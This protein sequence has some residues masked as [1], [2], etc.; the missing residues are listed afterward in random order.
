MLPITRRG[1]GRVFA[2]AGQ[3]TRRGRGGPPSG[4]AEAPTLARSS[5]RAPM[6]GSRPGAWAA[7]WA[8]VWLVGLLVAVVLL[9]ARP[10]QA[11]AATPAPRCAAGGH[12]VACPYGPAQLRAAY[13]IQPLI[14]QGIDGRGRTVVLLEQAQP[15][16]AA[17]TS[18]I[19]RDLDAFDQRFN[20]PPVAL[21]V[22]PTPADADPNAADIEEVMDAEL[23]HGVAPGAHIQ[24]LLADLKHPVTA[25]S[26]AVSKRLGDVIS[27]SLEF[28]ERCDTVAQAA[29]LHRVIERAA[30]QGM[31]LVASSGDYGAAG[32]PCVRGGILPANATATVSLLVADPL[33]T[34]V[35]GTRLDVEQSTGH[36]LG[37][38]VWNS[39]PRNQPVPPSAAPTGPGTNGSGTNGGRAYASVPHTEASGG[40]FSRLFPRPPFQAGVPGIGAGRGVPD[41]AA[42]A[43]PASPIATISAS[44]DGAAVL[45]GG[46]GTSIGAPIWAGLAAL[47][48]QQAGR[49][50][51]PLNPSLYR[52]GLGPEHATAFHDIT[53][54]NNDAQFPPRVITGFSAGPGWDPV[55]GWGSPDAAVLIPLLVHDATAHT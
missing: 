21:T 41:V 11:A 7:R 51:G 52:I 23:V 42:V 16:G 3:E 36:Y 33:V 40:G 28:S 8:A 2:D 18:D 34:A 12:A 50:L 49:G 25:L 19:Y 32:L 6:F 35:G 43:D 30:A 17:G 10:A 20:L 4:F 46:Y 1:V 15:H 13:D 47:A 31:T 45:K 39:P 24:V 27:M 54:G 29:A 14:D 37:E 22:T 26:L 44:N 55:T 48:D 53:A 9:Y 5:W 38:T